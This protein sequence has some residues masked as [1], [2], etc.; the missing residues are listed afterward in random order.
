M[1]KKI[2]NS[3]FPVC[4]LQRGMTYAELIVVLSIFATLTSVVLFNYQAFQAKVDIKVLANDI[5]L[6]IVEA[7]KNAS[8]GLLP[9]RSLSANWRPSYG[10]IFSTENPGDG[11]KFVY[12][13]DL[14]Q[15]GDYTVTTSCPGSAGSTNECLEEITITKGNA[16]TMLEVLGSG[17]PGI[18]D[19]LSIVF[20]RPDSGALISSSPG[21]FC[22]VNYVRISV[23]SP[24]GLGASIRVYPSGRVQID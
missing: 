22:E 23:A 13:A 18:V 11:Q 17:C 12:F 19:N 8:S 7:H 16:V 21:I 20:R 24:E 15:L 6:K 4:G 3:R 10:I 9:A 1:F 14:D 2:F 5:A